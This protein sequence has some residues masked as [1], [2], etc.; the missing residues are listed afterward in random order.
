MDNFFAQ[1]ENI[2]LE[3][4]FSGLGAKGI[5]PSDL[6]MG[7]KKTSILLFPSCAVLT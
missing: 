4:G 3:K 2:W 6:N 5:G 7:L 1:H